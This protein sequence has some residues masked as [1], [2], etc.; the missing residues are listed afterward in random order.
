MVVLRPQ[1]G[2]AKRNPPLDLIVG[3]G[4]QVALAPSDI[5]EQNLRMT[6]SPTSVRFDEETMW[7]ELTDG[8]TL[9]VPLASFPR[10]RDTAP[11]ERTKVE[12]S[13]LGL[14]WEALDED[15]SIAGLLAGHGATPAPRAGNETGAR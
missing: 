6:A 12:I 1:G 10:L 3:H 13:H 14:H 8:R 7:V 15:I 9:R 4:G 11:A 2:L 5:V